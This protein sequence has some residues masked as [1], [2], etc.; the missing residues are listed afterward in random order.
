MPTHTRIESIDILRALTMLFM[1][2]VNDFSTLSEVPKWLAHGP[3]GENY[4]GFSDLI[5][6]LFLFVVGMSIPLALQ[7]RLDK[8]H[9]SWS[10]TKHILIR[11]ASLLLIGVFIVNYEIAHN[12]TIV[13]GSQ[14]WGFIMALGV[15]LIWIDWRKSPIAQKFYLPIQCIGVCLLVFLAFVY[16]GGENGELG[17]RTHW[18]GI[19]GLI[20][21]AYLAN[22]LLA[23]ISRNKL[24]ISIVFF[25]IF[26][27]LSILNFAGPLSELPG[28]LSYFG[29]VLQ[30]FIPTFTAAGV[31]S[32]L[33]I[34]H[35]R[36]KSQILTFWI[37]LLFA[38]INILYAFLM[39]PYY[40]MIYKLGVS[41]A[42]SIICYAML[43]FLVEIKGFTKWA[44]FF[45]AA[46]TATL[47][48]YL[49]PYFYY[50]MR[51]ITGLRLPDMLNSGSIGLLVSF[52]YA[53]LVVLLASYMEKSGFK[54]KL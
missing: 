39:Q 33:L 43:Y 42:F 14:W 9:S 13:F 7:I 44:S 35:F 16:S 1:L 53:Y 3:A 12:A 2:W 52:G 17:M 18:W 27:I 19:L 31:V 46:G 4:I 25:V 5:F 29:T 26:N 20:G 38:A 51:E 54:L 47:T 10:I 32:T 23:L 24:L 48:C 11:G 22:S 30:G 28:V 50:P 6:P 41:I 40:W 49:I 45:T 21:W 8:N 37:L 36:Q 34:Q 15:V